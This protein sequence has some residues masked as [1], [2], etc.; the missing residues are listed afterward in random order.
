[1]LLTSRDHIVATTAW[2][3]VVVAASFVP[4]LLPQAQWL[5]LGQFALVFAATLNLCHA[6]YVAYS[7]GEPFRRRVREVVNDEFTD[8]LAAI[9]ECERGVEDVKQAQISIAGQFRGAGSRNHP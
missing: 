7:F 2:L 1:M 9:T 6:R 5:T 3:I 4:P 8:M